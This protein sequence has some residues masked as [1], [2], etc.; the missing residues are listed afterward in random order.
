MESLLA[1]RPAFIRPYRDTEL[2]ENP[3][4]YAA[5]RAAD[6][7]ADEKSEAPPLRYRGRLFDLFLLVEKDDKLYIIDQHAAHERMLFEK[8]LAGTIP[9][10]KLLV[11]LILDT[12]DEDED[13]FLEKKQ[14]DLARLGIVLGKEDGQWTVEALPAAWKAGDRETVKEIL[15]LKNASE[16]LA[17]RWAASLCCHEAIKDGDYLDGA[18][19]LDLAA[20]ALALPDP[21]CPHGRPLWV[22]IT[23]DELLRGVRRL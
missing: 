5:F 22:E 18:A 6:N 8:L 4:S 13:R 10:Q 7:A 14:Q 11:P 21:R 3:V 1:A 16:D 12:Q 19:A 15:N 2:H 9:L 17:R 20:A 23:K